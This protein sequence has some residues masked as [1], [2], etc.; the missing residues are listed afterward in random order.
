MIYNIFMTIYQNTPKDKPP[1]KPPADDK[2]DEFTCII[3]KDTRL[4]TCNQFKK[5]STKIIYLISSFMF[6]IKTQILVN[7]TKMQ[8]ALYGTTFEEM[9]PMY[10]GI[11]Q[12]G[13][14]VILLN[15]MRL[16]KHNI[17]IAYLFKLCENKYQLNP[18]KII[19]FTQNAQETANNISYN[20]QDL[21]S[22]KND[23]LQMS[24][25]EY[26]IKTNTLTIDNTFDLYNT[27]NNILN[28]EIIQLNPKGKCII[29][30]DNKIVFYLDHVTE[31]TIK[32]QDK[33]LPK[34]IIDL[35]KANEINFI[36]GLI[37]INADSMETIDKFHELTIP[38]ELDSEQRKN[39][40]ES[41]II[42]TVFKRLGCGFT[43]EMLEIKLSKMTQ[44]EIN[45]K[46]ID[47]IGNST[48]SQ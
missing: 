37:D 48:K 46:H 7:D 30:K 8:L 38:Q 29:R 11:E 17:I 43:G 34:F 36:P 1:S 40:L 5:L 13:F 16:A 3:Q 39:W 21:I 10:Y 6:N 20:S 2:L 14:H 32:T 9:L 4:E 42:S 15:L 19:N 31:V 28:L 33:Y 35:Y 27:V 24:G 12:G 47:L 22:I 26:N 41:G 18:T 45:E 25:L 23:I 44:K